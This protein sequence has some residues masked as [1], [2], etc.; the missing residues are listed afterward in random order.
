MISAD[1][2]ADQGIAVQ[3]ATPED[4]GAREK[5]RTLL[6]S[7]AADPANGIDAVLDRP[8]IDRLEADPRASFWVDMKP[9]Y[10]ISGALDPDGPLAAARRPA[11]THGYAPTHPDM[12]SL[13]LLAGP[14]VP[15]GADVGP[16]DM[17]SIAPTLARL[18]YVPFPSAERPALD[19][20]TA[21]R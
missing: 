8:A 11:G 19:I 12:D 5:V 21:S 1:P 20:M 15:S 6:E 17:R 9:G 13:F 16:I 18:M 10:S 7:L 4:A 14:G 2:P 3:S